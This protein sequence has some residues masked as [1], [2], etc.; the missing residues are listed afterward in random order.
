MAVSHCIA[1]HW[2]EKQLQNLFSLKFQ[3]K[4]L[5]VASTFFNFKYFRL[6]GTCKKYLRLKRTCKSILGIGRTTVWFF[7]VEILFRTWKKMCVDLF[8]IMWYLVIINIQRTNKRT[9]RVDI[10]FTPPGWWKIEIQYNCTSMYNK[11]QCVWHT[12]WRMGIW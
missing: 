7:S 9:I 10:V 5:W 4:S 8:T 2:G 12:I 11:H 3:I 1:L 6:K